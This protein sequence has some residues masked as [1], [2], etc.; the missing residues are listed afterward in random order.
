MKRAEL[1]RTIPLERRAPLKKASDKVRRTKQEC[2]RLRC[3]RSAARGLNLCL[4]H[5]KREADRL[6]SLVV[7]K[8]DGLCCYCGTYDQL[9]CAHILSRSYLSVR[10]D[11][12]NAIALCKSH[13][14]YFT[15][16][17]LEWEEWIERALPGRRDLLRRLALPYFTDGYAERSKPDY[18]SLISALRAQLKEVSA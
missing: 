9:Q 17:P 13:H 16:R 10:F 1:K 4:T 11:T 3:K 18:A 6:F 5:A 8:R 2:S 15:H 12:R 14:V 7:R